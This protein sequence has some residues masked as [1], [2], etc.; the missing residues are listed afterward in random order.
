VSNDI[1]ID[2]ASMLT[3]KMRSVLSEYQLKVIPIDD[4][5]A[6]IVGR[7]YALHFSADRDG[8]EV[9]YI[10]H[11][12]Q[13]GLTEYAFRPL[14]MQRF[15]KEDRNHYGNPVTI[16]E[17]INSGISVYASGLVNSCRDVLSG[18][19]SWIKRD[20]WVIG[21]PSEEIERVLLMEFC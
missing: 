5:E 15:T 17:R 10:D 21:K 19:K 8:V 12:K 16:L 14:V 20:I 4:E 6:L 9:S 3:D 2:V 7:N 1:L 18:D 11:D 13:Y